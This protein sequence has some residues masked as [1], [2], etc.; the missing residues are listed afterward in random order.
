MEVLYL[1]MQRKYSELQ[2]EYRNKE[3]ERKSEI[4]SQR[5]DFQQRLD[6]EQNEKKRL[7]KE[8]VS[9]DWS[10]CW[11]LLKRHF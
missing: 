9:F 6:A 3:V 10:F 1:D 8:L 11:Q 5:T 4:V 2:T 7:A